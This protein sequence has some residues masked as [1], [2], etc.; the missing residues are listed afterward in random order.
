MF[1]GESLERDAKGGE[2]NDDASDA[3]ANADDEYGEGDGD[4]GAAGSQ[5]VGR[6]VFPWSNERRPAGGGKR[7]LAGALTLV[8]SLP[9]AL[10][11]AAPA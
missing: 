9:F 8:A 6:G 11:L 1:G 5:G 3:V 7:S 4:E 2:G 10:A